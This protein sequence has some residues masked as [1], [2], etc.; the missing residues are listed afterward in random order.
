MVKGVEFTNVRK[1]RGG[2]ECDAELH[3]V[4]NWLTQYH[5]RVLAEGF[6]NIQIKA[7]LR[8]REGQWIL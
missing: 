3:V 4:A 7:A 6:E 1:L 5:D 2:N 8:A